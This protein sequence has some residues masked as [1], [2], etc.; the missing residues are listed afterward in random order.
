MMQ[1]GRNFISVEVRMFLTRI[2]QA[3]RGRKSPARIPSRLTLEEFEPRMVPAC[4]TPPAQCFL[5]Q[6]YRDVLAREIDPTGLNGWTQALAGGLTR[7]QVA[8]AIAGSQDFRVL[9]VQRAYN[10]FLGRAADQFGLN[11]FTAFLASG[12]SIEQMQAIIIGSPEYSLRGDNASA[13]GF[14]RSVYRDVLGRA[15]DQ[16]GETAFTLLLASGASRSAV[17]LTFL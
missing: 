13:V 9:V 7:Q 6:L 4:T 8:L 17:A 1:G 15:A 12:A 16:A 10:Q 11:T 5:S 3:L 14:V 2:R